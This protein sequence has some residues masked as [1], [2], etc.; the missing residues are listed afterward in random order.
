MALVSVARRYY[1]RVLART[2]G[3]DAE[4]VRGTWARIWVVG[5]PKCGVR[6]RT[7]DLRV[8][9]RRGI[10]EKNTRVQVRGRFGHLRGRVA[11][12]ENTTRGGLTEGQDRYTSGEMCRL[13][14]DVLRQGEQ[15]PFAFERAVE[16]LR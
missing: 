1:V 9:L 6:H 4:E 10:G 5:N 8:H 7:S 16:A 3:E 14:Y 13:T 12:G 11:Q 15:G 2:R